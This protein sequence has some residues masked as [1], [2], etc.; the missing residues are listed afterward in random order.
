MN[1][2]KT[3]QLEEEL[4]N[5]LVENPHKEIEKGI[6]LLRDIYKAGDK[7]PEEI[8]FISIGIEKMILYSLQKNYVNNKEA[9]R[10]LN[11]L[12]QIKRTI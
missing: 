10:Y 3:N 5:I 1:E 4:D 7:N 12:Y 9:Q 8:L 11:N 2:T 6:S